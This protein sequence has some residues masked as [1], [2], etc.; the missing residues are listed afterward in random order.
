V[1][2]RRNHAV[3][4]PPAD[5][6]L[7]PRRDAPL[8]FPYSAFG[9]LTPDDYATLGFICG[10]EVHQQ[11]VTRRKLFCRCPAG[12]SM[13]QVDGEVLRHMRPTLSELGYYDG[14][15]LMEFKTRKDIVYL[16]D[17]HCVCTYELDDTPPFEMDAEAV[18]IALEISRMYGLSLVSELQVM[19]KQ[20]LDGSIPTGFQ[21][22]AMIAVGGVIPFRESELGPGRELRLRQ[23]TLEED[24]CREVSDVGHRITFKTDRLGM[25]LVE[26]VTEPELLTPHDVEAGGRLL[27]RVAR[28]SGK[29]RRGSGAARQDVNVSVAGGRRVEIKGV[30]HHRGLPLV[31]HNEAFRQ[32][33]LMKIGAELLERGVTKEMLDISDERVAWDFRLV[34]DARQALRDCAYIPVAEALERGDFLAV[35]R[36]PRFGRLL[37]WRTQPGMTFAHEFADRVRVIA[38]LASRPFMIASHIEDYGLKATTWRRLRSAV[39]AE[40]DDALVVVWGPWNDVDTA[41]REILLRAQDALDGVPSETRQVFRDGTNGLERILPGP[42]RMYP[43]TD[44][45]P[46]PIPDAWVEEVE[47]RLRERPWEREDRYVGLGLPRDAAARLA[48]ATWADLFDALAPQTEACRRRLAHALEKRLVRHWRAERHRDLPTAQRLRPLIEAV[49][50]GRVRAEAFEAVLDRLLADL[51]E[52]P[53]D[54]LADFVPDGTE[55]EELELHVAAVL[56]EVGAADGRPHDA[57][58]RRALGMAMPPLLGK[59]DPAHVRDRVAQA[60]GIPG[61]GATS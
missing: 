58:L 25:P 48:A 13:R 14:C 17:R 42:E 5:F 47:A 29:V 24:S 46:Y 18:R 49:D 35:V 34:A 57:L 43:D 8:D 32:L 27:A 36:L 16:L 61:G 41:C 44:T 28:A 40:E 23:L 52:T 15:A 39:D 21:R 4:A 45:P 6:D 54:V 51:D 56:R 12:Y 11:L 10:L 50:A 53:Q 38:C 60:L 20:Y 31:V 19:R 26:T 3:A 59:A 22:S 9:A 1:K 30:S 55:E 2:R 7:N 37:G 33:E